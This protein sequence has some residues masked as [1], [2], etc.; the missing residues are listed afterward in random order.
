M[1]N[2][3]A[4]DEALEKFNTMKLK[5]K[6]AYIVFHIRKNPEDGKLE[7][8]HHEAIVNKE[9][10]D[11]GDDYREHFIDALKESKQ[12]RF[13]VVDWNNKLL[14]V[15]WV[16][17]TAKPKSKMKYASVKEAFIQSLVGIQHKVHATDDGELNSDVIEEQTKSNV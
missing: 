7:E 16:P 1:L 11:V 17:E 8:I 10:E 15:S 5:H 3:K 9:D 12:S 13:G 4:T 2:I 14:F 6:I